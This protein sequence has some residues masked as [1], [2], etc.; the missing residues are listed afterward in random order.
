MKRRVCGLRVWKRN[1]TMK[2]RVLKEHDQ[3]TSAPHG[4]HASGTG[5]WSRNHAHPP[6]TPNIR[7]RDALSFLLH[8]EQLL[9]DLQWQLQHGVGGDFEKLER[10]ILIKERFVKKLRREFENARR[11][12]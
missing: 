2:R 1:K 11:P 3:T 7:K 12:D 10:N 8:H 4:F 9:M 6:Q 5:Q